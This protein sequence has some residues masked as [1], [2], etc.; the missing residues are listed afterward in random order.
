MNITAYS[1]DSKY[2][3][4]NVSIASIGKDYMVIST[5]EFFY[6]FI[7]SYDRLPI[8]AIMHP[9]DIDEFYD[10]VARL[11]E[12]DQHI[13][14]RLKNGANVY[15]YYKIKLWYN[16]RIIDG[17]RS[18]NM[19]IMDIVIIE[20]RYKEL[21][22]N[23][24]KYRHY[25]ALANEYFFEYD[26][27]TNI[28]TFFMYVNDRSNIVVREDFDVFCNLMRKKYLTE[29][30]RNQFETFVSYLKTGVDSFNVQFSTTFLSKA[31][32]MDRLIFNGSTF[33]YN[34]QKKIV[35]G[36][37]KSLKRKWIEKAYYQTEASIDCS[38]GL[39]NKRGIME[40]VSDRIRLSE[41]K[42]IEVIILDV[43]DFKTIN[44]T[45]GHLF[46]DEVISKVSDVIKSVVGSRGVVG[47]FGGDEFMIIMEDFGNN[48]EI[49]SMLKTIENKLSWIY[50]GL[51]DDVT[52]TASIGVS[53]Y[54]DDGST[55]EELFIKADKAL[56]I[57][58]ENGKNCFVIYNDNI[59][60]NIKLSQSTKMKVQSAI[61]NLGDV[62]SESVLELHSYGVSAIPG[63]LKRINDTLGVS[64]ITVYTGSDLRN[65]Y[66]T[67]A[68][69]KKLDSFYDI[70]TAEHFSL[71]NKSGE[72]VV[73]DTEILDEI[74]D[75]NMPDYK[76]YGIT[77]YYHCAVYSGDSPVVLISYDMMDQMYDW[78][79]SEIN[80]LRVIT[81]M[82][83]QI[84]M[85]S[86][87]VNPL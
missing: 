61:V 37:V 19:S 46:G 86:D 53:K 10:A 24:R 31:S 32:R 30:S 38:T 21:D 42:S 49:S 75:I 67:G 62:V 35:M 43:D 70:H 65:T 18:Y 5:D 85:E 45:H 66:S 14:I 78:N 51:K 9:D 68:Y 77:A 44:D 59:H 52:V 83:G 8:T 55:Y 36:T 82:I 87:T 71:F 76:N 11:D 79:I 57:A 64:G 29:D 28:F 26:I 7:G 4:L 40:Y 25:M 23:V 16:D 72:F 20:A 48:D 15:R 56:Y 80:S 1:A 63:I 17:F 27:K 3:N 33:Y 60:Q 39:I 47:R 73:R 34:E 13:I 58:K 22:F 6:E 69:A 54:P 74:C 41:S 81:K 12:G 84:L 2:K 50:K